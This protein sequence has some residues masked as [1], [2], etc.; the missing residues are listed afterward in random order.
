LVAEAVAVP[1]VAPV[2]LTF[3]EPKVEVTEADAAIPAGLT[4]VTFVVAVQPLLS[5]VVTE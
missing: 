5:V 3:P 2:Q 4:M 1:F